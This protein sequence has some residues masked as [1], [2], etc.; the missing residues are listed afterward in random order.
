MALKETKGNYGKL[1]SLWTGLFVIT[2]IQ[3]NNTFILHS[4]EG[5]EV[6][7]GPVNGRFLKLYFI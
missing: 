3:Q 5:E 7:G 4:L 1:D 6:F 2:Q